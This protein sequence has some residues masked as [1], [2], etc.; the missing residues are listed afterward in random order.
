[1]LAVS[2]LS[3]SA[4]AQKSALNSAKSDYD[5]YSTLKGASPAI[6]GPKLQAAKESIDKASLH[7]KTKG[8]PLTWLTKAKI[9][10]A[11]AEADSTSAS[12][13]LAEEAA[14][15]FTKAKELDTT[16]AQKEEL[17]K[18]AQVLA[19][20]QLI[21]G[22]GFLD[23]SKYAEAYKEF[24]KGLE[25]HPGDTTLNY[26][27]G[28]SAM[29]G[30][31]NA[32]AI[33]R[34]KELT[35]TNYSQNE[36]IYTWLSMLYMQEKDTVNAL[37]T[38]NEGVSKF[39]NSKDLATKE[40]EFNLMAGK[41]KEVIE[42]INQQATKDP[43]NK[44]FPFYLGIAYNA[45]NN[46]PKAEESYKKAIALDPAYT[47]AYI[48]LGGLMMNRGIEL[49]NK[50]NKLPANKQTEYNAQMKLAMVEFDKAFPYLEKATELDAKSELAL[51]NLKT[52]YQIKKNEA[53]MK[54]IDEKIK[55]L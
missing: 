32:N 34:F 50:A 16:G 17:A 28:I 26:A 14:T 45:A 12:A 48:N 44:L 10:S 46:L 5:S 6:A 3:F 47:D 53:K 19:Y 33:A 27:A 13:T 54:E 37:K 52:Y 15:A 55:A 38:L 24:S 25:Y 9:Y 30:K 22:K 11:L 49:Y 23:N 2:G 36:N 31:D 40:I 21:K 1:M 51:R 29:N 7:E 39:P 4:M 35:P 41:E 18:T 20:S 42:K 43:S 8:D